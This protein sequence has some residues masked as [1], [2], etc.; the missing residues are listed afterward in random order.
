MS[1]SL[2]VLLAV[3]VVAAILIFMNGPRPANREPAGEAAEAPEPLEDD[4]IGES[5]DDSDSGEPVVETRAPVTSDGVVLIRGAHEVRL[6]HLAPGEEVPEWLGSGIAAGSVPYP[7]LHRHAGHAAQGGTSLR[8]GDLTGARLRRES[9]GPWR[10]E[11]LGRDGDFGLFAFET[12]AGARDALALLEA[13][14]VR[15][16]AGEDGEPVPPSAEDFEEARRRYEETERHLA[17]SGDED[18]PPPPAEW[19][20]RR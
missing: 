5:P 19:S 9:G 11:T 3:T 2:V 7:V 16:P 18:E 13:A 12:E 4:E 17:L 6:L 1:P 14:I 8:A 10:L 15:R 20:S